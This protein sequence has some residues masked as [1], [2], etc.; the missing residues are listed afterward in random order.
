MGVAHPGVSAAW[1]C[2]RASTRETLLPAPAGSAVGAG[3][4]RE[5]VL[6]LLVGQ[7]CLLL[8]CAQFYHFPSPPGFESWSAA[9]LATSAAAAP[10]PVPAQLARTAASAQLVLVTAVVVLA[11]F[12]L[13]TPLLVLQLWQERARPCPLPSRRGSSSLPPSRRQVSLNVTTIEVMQWRQQG[14]PVPCLPERRMRHWQQ[15]SPH[16]RGSTWLNFADFVRGS[17]ESSHEG[18]ELLQV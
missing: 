14:E 16:D 15:F 6:M 17:R 7:L 1:P 11:M 12:I 13:L 10:A 9:A 4:H 8:F 3:N 2:A 18:V 5:F